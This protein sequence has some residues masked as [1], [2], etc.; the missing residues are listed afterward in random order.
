MILF[1][2][3]S[4]LLNKLFEYPASYLVAIVPVRVPHPCILAAR[5]ATNAGNIQGNTTTD[6][7][8]YENVNKNA[9]KLRHAMASQ[10]KPG[11]AK[12]SQA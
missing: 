2:N 4:C 5:K 8:I 7:S 1:L 6:T 11:K 3:S 10:G 9:S 12:Q